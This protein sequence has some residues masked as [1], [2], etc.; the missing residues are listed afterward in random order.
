MRLFLIFL[1]LFISKITVAEL[2]KPSPE[3]LPEEVVSIQLKALQKNNI[4]Y[5]DAGIEQTWEFAHPDN[6]KFTGPLSKFISMMH[7]LSYSIILEH[8]K[9]NIIFVKDYDLQTFYFVELIDYKGVKVGFKWIV[10]K[11]LD[12]GKYKDCWMTIR[13]SQPIKLSKST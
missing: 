11:V 2:I 10:D 7:T 1:F 4:P 12:E 13:V 6:R 9:H 5:K 3:L 8:M